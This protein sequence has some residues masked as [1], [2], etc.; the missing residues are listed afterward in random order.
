MARP[1]FTE[2][3]FYL[4]G[5]VQRQSVVSFIDGLPVDEKRP[6]EIVVREKPKKRTPDQQ[7]LLFAGPMRDIAE[8]AVFEGKRYSVEVLH[9]LCKREFLPEE[10]DP[11]QCLEGYVKWDIDPTGDRVLVGSTK[12]LTSYGYS[13]YLEQVFAFGANLGVRFSANPNERKYHG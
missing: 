6:L 12:Q 9:H 4:V 1:P 10:F 8:Q 11:E 2:R 5:E 7:A 3:K 13:L